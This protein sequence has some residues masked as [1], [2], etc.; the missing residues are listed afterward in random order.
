MLISPSFW[1]RVQDGAAIVSRG[2]CL[3]H[4]TIQATQ[5]PTKKTSQQKSHESLRQSSKFSCIE[6]ILIFAIAPMKNP[7][8]Q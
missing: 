6:M 1:V 4:Q 3:Q 5:I 7:A 2:G 8:I